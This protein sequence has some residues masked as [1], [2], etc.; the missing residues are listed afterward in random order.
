MS[1]HELRILNGFIGFTMPN[2]GTWPSVLAPYEYIV[3]GLEQRLTVEHEGK[4]LN[5]TPEAVFHSKS[6]SQFM[7]VEIKRGSFRHRQALGYRQLNSSSLLAVGLASEGV[8]G[9]QTHDVLFLC[10]E[11]HADDLEGR[12]SSGGFDFPV[13]R[14][15]E[16]VVRSAFGRYANRNL[17]AVF[18]RGVGVEDHQWPT[19]FVTIDRDSDAGDLSPKVIRHAIQ[20]LIMQP[21]FETDELCDD[22]VDFWAQRGERDRNTIRNKVTAILDCAANEELQGYIKRQS[23]RPL[24]ERAGAREWGPTALD[25]ISDL[26]ESF[27]HRQIAGIPYRPGQLRLF[28]Y[29]EGLP[30]QDLNP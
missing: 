4:I 24:F 15:S 12:L 2:A 1:R 11:E 26:V 3:T 7:I 22:I 8:S 25:L 20:L 14:F 30:E 5:P 29:E 6:E 19:H 18:V 16:V 28:P 17:E 13:I 21:R 23:K 27:V 9:P 10:N